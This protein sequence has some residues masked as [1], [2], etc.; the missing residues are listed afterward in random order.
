MLLLEIDLVAIYHQ[1]PIFFKWLFF[2]YFLTLAASYIVMM[3]VSR[4]A[5]IDHKRVNSF[6]DYDTILDSPVQPSL[7]IIAPAY[8]ECKTIVENIN[9]LLSMKYLNYEVI[10][11]NDGSTDETMEFIIP[12]F[13]LE[14]IEYNYTASIETKTVLSIYK[15]NNPE[16]KHLLVVNKV[17][18]GK[19]DAL[20]VG[21]NVAKGKYFA[22]I[23]VDCIIDRKALLNMAKPFMEHNTSR[24]I[25]TGAV[26]GVSNNCDVEEGTIQQMRMPKSWL[27]SIQTMEYFRAFLLGRMSWSKINGSILISGAFGFFDKDLAIEVGG[28]DHRTVGEDMEL[29]MRMRRHMLETNIKH[30]VTFSPEPMCWTEVPESH[31]VLKNQRNRWARGTIESLW[32]HRK[33]FFNRKYGVLGWLSLPYWLIFEWLGPIIEFTGILYF[34]LCAYLGFVNWHFFYAVLLLVYF[35]SCFVSLISVVFHEYSY[36]QYTRNKDILKLIFSCFVDP[37]IFHPRTMLFSIYGNLNKLYKR[38]TSWGNMERQGFRKK[39]AVINE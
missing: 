15:S 11:V 29:T 2:I 6:I 12:A 28:Y 10:I 4:L 1:I 34:L 8:N 23:D 33:M 38:Q 32:T 16:W 25:A 37:I 24:V 5:I 13:E 35:F 36:K 21:L 18:G 27:A 14:K 22:C 7:S 20:N 17:N 30:I 9:S 26:I 31:N 3:Y 39:K 19:S